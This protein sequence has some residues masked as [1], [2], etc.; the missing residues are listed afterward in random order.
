MLSWLVV[1]D[2]RCWLPKLVLTTAG[3]P[4]AW[5]HPSPRQRSGP[6]LN[7]NPKGLSPAQSGRQDTLPT[8]GTI[9]WDFILSKGTFQ[10]D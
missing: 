4:C 2:C 10:P 6:A 7:T 1:G 5:L 9:S 3:A 8:L